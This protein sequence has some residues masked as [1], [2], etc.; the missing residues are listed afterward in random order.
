MI[1]ERAAASE[2]PML[3]R[4][5]RPADPAAKREPTGPLWGISGPAASARA[6]NAAAERQGCSTSLL[7]ARGGGSRDGSTFHWEA[8]HGT[9]QRFRRSQSALPSQPRGGG[10]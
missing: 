1:L 2:V 8:G 6:L 4:P 3:E 10:A 7:L 9:R 5:G